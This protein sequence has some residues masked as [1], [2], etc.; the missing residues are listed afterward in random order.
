MFKALLVSLFLHLLLFSL[1]FFRSHENKSP[2]SPPVVLKFKLSEPKKD[3]KLSNKEKGNIIPKATLPNESSKGCTNYFG[4]IGI[5]TS[6]NTI[7][8][9]YEGYPASSKLQAEDEIIDPIFPSEIR[10]KVDTPISIIVLRNG[11]RLAF[12]F[13]RAKICIED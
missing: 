13:V 3:K 4:G 11:K 5:T 8:R 1:L 10:G 12:T 9:V 7:V 2:S 6:G